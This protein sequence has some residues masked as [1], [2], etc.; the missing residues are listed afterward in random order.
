MQKIFDY[1]SN[2]VKAAKSKDKGENRA[3][4]VA[5][6]TAFALAVVKFIAGLASGSVAVLGS[7]VD[8]ALDCVVSLLNFLAL[9]KS[10]A[11]ANANF[12]FGYGKLEA[13]A[14]MF[15]G[16]FIIGAAAFI[17]YESLLKFNQKIAEIDLNLGICVM[18]FSLAVTGG[19]IA[20]LGSVAK[21]TANLIVKADALHYRSDFYANLA[22]IAALVVV[23]FTGL[24]AIDAI[25]G[26]IIS[27][28]IAH[29]ALN[30]I[31]ESLGVLLD[32]A[33][34]PEITAR[35]EEI[36]KSKKEIL[37]YHYLTSRKSGGSCFLSVHLV[38]ERGISLFDA[39]AVSDGVENEI[40]AEFSEL[41]WQ[42]T[43]HLDPCDDRLGACQI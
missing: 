16:I 6:A 38:F 2:A 23:K 32:R 34:E 41:S 39:H 40:K 13:V 22:V 5:G 20:F 30:L 14:A 19:L 1:E 42:I 12:N 28:L 8:S 27:G 15:E 35:I 18:L 3:V 10:R 21:R 24:T 17:C 36:I 31:K 9:K 7:A 4:V 29:S 33:L 37:S 43:A 25:F 26:L 11:A